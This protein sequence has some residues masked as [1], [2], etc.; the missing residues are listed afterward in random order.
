MAV[1]GVSSVA[2]A[3]G[4][5]DLVLRDLGAGK[6]HRAGELIVKFRDGVDADQRGA[7]RGGLR[8][9]QARTV[10]R[11]RNGGDVELMRLP[12]GMALGVAIKALQNDPA[13]EYAEPNW[14]YQ[15]FATSN[16]TY[17]TN[18]SLWGMYG[19]TTSPSNAYGS[20]AAE[21][22]AAGHTDC[23][24]V[25]VGVIDEGIYYNHE[26]LAANVWTNPYDPVDGIDND[27]NGYVDDVHGWDFE[28]GG[29]D[30]NSGGSNDDHGTHVSGTI[31]GVGGNGKGVAGVCWSGVKLISGRFLG[32]RGGST[33]DAIEAVDYMT[34][35]KVR[36]NMNIVATNNSWGGGGFSQALQDAI[37][38]AGDADILFIA[39][40]GND[41]YDND[42]RASYPSNYSNANIIA[43]AS[44]TSSGALSSFSQWGATTVDLGAPGSA[45]YST[46]PVRSKGNVVS[47]YASYSGTSMATPHV[48]GAAALYASSHPTATAAQIKAA[49]LN[50]TVATPSLQGK[51][52]T[53]GRLDASGF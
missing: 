36:H 20:Q 43:V 3:G 5:P 32:R 12:A 22:W 21:A 35:L 8:A 50:A 40:A 1:L 53:G 45:I 42:A 39:A 26:D 25:Y 31:A 17:Y 18:G 52:L 10:H 33:A 11:G 47:G 38:R 51:V 13:V 30:V 19:N 14:T 41:A 16:D 24:N 6:A 27:G 46:V 23:S 29:N 7:V 37:G 2:V 34:D 28:G 4:R 49:I 15:H 48:T 44:I 9:Q